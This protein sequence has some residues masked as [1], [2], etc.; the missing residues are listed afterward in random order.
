MQATDGKGL[1]ARHPTGMENGTPAPG[2][3][4]TDLALLSELARVAGWDWDVPNDELTWSRGL[5]ELFGVDP[6][7]FEPTYERFIELVHPEDRGSVEAAIGR[8]LESGGSSYRIV[9]RI[10]RPD[11]GERLALCRA[12]TF[13]DGAG[14][15]VRMVGATLDLS[16]LQEVASEMRARLDHVVAAEELAGIGSFEWVVETDRTT[17]S[18][19][20]YRVFGLRPDE[21]VGTATAYFELIH[22]EDRDR[23]RSAIEQL[24]RDGDKRV[25]EYRIVRRDG[26]VRRVRSHISVERDGDGAP[27]RVL[28]VCR[29]VTDE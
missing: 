24:L 12:R 26:E 15:A 3:G 11:G 13:R 29:D 8:N 25:D 22:P 2:A 10:V 9:H 14:R 19:G 6:E 18:Q 28:G 16:D 27:E 20:L 17:W 7:T 4:A 1:E 23:Q 5:Y 21:F